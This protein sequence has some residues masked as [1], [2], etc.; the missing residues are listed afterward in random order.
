[1]RKIKTILSAACLLVFL[2]ATTAMAAEVVQGACVSYDAEKHIVVVEEFDLNFTPENKY[3]Q[4]TGIQSE[5]DTATAKVGITPEPGDV[6]RIAYVLE[7]DTKTALKVM[8]VSKQ[9]LRKK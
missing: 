8:N 5:F 7:G 1:M 9:D 6:L 3:G 2:A 4:S